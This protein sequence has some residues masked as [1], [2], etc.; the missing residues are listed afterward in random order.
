MVIYVILG[1][2]FY[3]IRDQFSILLDLKWDYNEEK[4]CLFFAN[5]TGST[6]SQNIFP[7]MKKLFLKTYFIHTYV[8]QDLDLAPVCASNWHLKH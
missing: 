8:K 1:V 4:Q 2:I 7:N 3:G 5:W 6:C